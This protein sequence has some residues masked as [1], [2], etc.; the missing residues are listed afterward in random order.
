MG[1]VLGVMT[2][3]E[4]IRQFAVG[5]LSGIKFNLDRL[6]MISQIIVGG[7][8][9]CSSRV[10]DTSAYNAFDNPEPGIGTPESA[11]RKGCGFC[12]R[13]CRGI[14]NEH[15]SGNST[16][17]KPHHACSDDDYNPPSH[18]YCSLLSAILLHEAVITLCGY[19]PILAIISSA[20]FLASSR[21]PWSG[22]PSALWAS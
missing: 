9:F 5:Y 15:P 10:S 4:E 12:P 18:A 3:P 22:C 8:V 21:S 11:E 13:C 14:Y 7:I 1:S 6:G 2:D 20:N 17:E 19:E 16:Q